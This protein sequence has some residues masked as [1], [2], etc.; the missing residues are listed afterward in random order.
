MRHNHRISFTI[1]MLMTLGSETVWAQS[2]TSL[3]DNFKWVSRISV[4]ISQLHR[5]DHSAELVDIRIGRTI[6]RG[7]TSFDFGVIGSGSRG[8]FMG[9]TAGL[10]TQPWHAKR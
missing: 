3:E 7:S 1:V 9:L 2:P 4:G 8:P 5:W 10:E 6:G